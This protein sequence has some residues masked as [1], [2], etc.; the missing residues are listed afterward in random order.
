MDANHKRAKEN[1]SHC[2][3]RYSR[4][5][6][7]VDGGSRLAH[8]GGLLEGTLEE[9]RVGDSLDVNLQLSHALGAVY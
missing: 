5:R 8:D 1:S 2:C 3:H 9:E 6:L 7:P 4:G